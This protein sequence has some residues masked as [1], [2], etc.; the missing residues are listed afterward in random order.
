MFNTRLPKFTDLVVRQAL[1]LL[2][3]FEWANRT[4]SLENT[5]AL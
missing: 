5:N 4:C 3:D 2:Y 1:S